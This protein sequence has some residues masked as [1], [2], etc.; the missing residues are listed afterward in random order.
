MAG[1]TEEVLSVRGLVQRR[2]S[3]PF[4]LRGKVIMKRAR[5]VGLMLGLAMLV[6]AAQ[7]SAA[8][9]IYTDEG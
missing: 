8:P 7:A 4:G 1:D 3:G 9:I 6:G 2:A 5:I